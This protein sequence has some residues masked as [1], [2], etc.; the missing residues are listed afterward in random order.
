MAIDRILHPAGAI[1]Q[2]RDRYAE[3]GVEQ[4]ESQSTEQTELAVGQVE[5]EF[6]RLEQN[7]EDRSIH[8]IHHVAEKQHGECVVAISG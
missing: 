1:G 2:R 6:D 5:V 4:C 7:S 8:E 3:R